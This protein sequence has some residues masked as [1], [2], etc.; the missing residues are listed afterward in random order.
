M[1][2][3]HHELL[4]NWGVIEVLNERLSFCK[5]DIMSIC[6]ADSEREQKNCKFYKKS[7]FSD[8]CMHFMFDEYCDCL[9]AQVAIQQTQQSVEEN[10]IWI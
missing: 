5:R 6:T 4:K 7:S 10:Y 3:I 1:L 9:E 2:S 8:R